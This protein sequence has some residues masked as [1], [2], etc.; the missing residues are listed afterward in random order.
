[1]KPAT[2]KSYYPSL[3]GLR[4]IAILLVLFHH[5]F[6][7][8]PFAQYAYVGVDLFFVLSGF[9]ITDILL[10]TRD[11]K[12]FLQNFFIRRILRIFPLYYVMLLLF[13]LFV[14]FVSQLHEQYKYYH[15]NQGMAW[16]HLINWLY[17]FNERPTDSMLFGHFWSL[18]VEEQF[19][20]LWPFL[21][22]LC[23]NLQKLKM[24]I[25]IIL[26]IGIGARFGTW[27]YWGGNY[28]GFS[29]QYMTRFDGLCM[30]SLI[31]I[32]K[33]SNQ[34]SLA[35]KFLYFLVTILI[36]HGCLFLLSR[37]VF[38]G[39]PHFILLGYTGI[40]AI[41]GLIVLSATS[42]TLNIG[43]PVLEN[44]LLK[45]FGRISYGLYVFHWPV[46]ILL[47]FSLQD[48]ILRN[49]I[50]LTMAQFIIAVSTLFVATL[51]SILSYNMFEKRIL[52][53]RDTMTENGYFA[54]L[55]QKLLLLMRPASA[56]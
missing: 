32:W 47:R 41:F 17:I 5:T 53:L 14:P 18:S 37:T 55:R 26:I 36:I 56:K 40:A 35:K 33:F 7:F 22:L 48:T 19:Y 12:N 10:R 23:R 20:L 45:Y 27:L 51:I 16:F 34:G 49:G 43:K 2:L 25:Y 6:D 13:F 44:R 29:F 30:G 1:M 11:N 21:V 15:D 9:L 38:I 52:A 24:I 28:T 39:L 50:S 3:D 42:R 31:A 54:R 4:G 8:I 46:F